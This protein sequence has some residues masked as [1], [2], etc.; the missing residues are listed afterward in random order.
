MLFLP[1]CAFG[2]LVVWVYTASPWGSLMATCG[3]ILVENRDKLCTL[4]LN[5]SCPVK[6]EVPT[7]TGTSWALQDRLYAR[8]CVLESEDHKQK[9]FFVVVS[10]EP[11]IRKA[12]TPVYRNLWAEGLVSKHTFPRLGVN[13]T[14]WVGGCENFSGLAPKSLERNWI[15]HDLI[16]LESNEMENLP[17]K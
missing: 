13:V 5:G 6:W 7:L 16:F 14:L 15:A 8:K 1:C 10:T 9:C 4:M 12:R 3:R 2:A 11:K 17:G